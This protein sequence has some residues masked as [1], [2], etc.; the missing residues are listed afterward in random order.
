MYLWSYINITAFKRSL[1]M[2]FLYIFLMYLKIEF[3]LSTQALIAGK[4]NNIS[5][6]LITLGNIFPIY[7][8]LMTEMVWD[9]DFGF[10]FSFAQ[11]YFHS[12]SC[13]WKLDGPGRSSLSY[14][15]T[16]AWSS[17]LHCS[18]LLTALIVVASLPWNLS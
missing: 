7:F 13:C 4:T 17:A 1:F 18:K 16:S 6:T 11:F 2:L 8:S 12:C 15:N 10:S 5:K 3:D 9:R 14:F